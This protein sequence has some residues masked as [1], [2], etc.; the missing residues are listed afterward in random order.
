MFENENQSGLCLILIFIIMLEILI[1]VFKTI[2]TNS[3]LDQV[4]N[5]IR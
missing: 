4:L 5:F 3:N 1:Y 2:V